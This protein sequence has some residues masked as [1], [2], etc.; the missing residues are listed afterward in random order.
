MP[1]RARPARCSAAVGAALC[2]LAGCTA[3]RTEP[4]V[5][6]APPA[7][8]KTI[9]VEAFVPAELAWTRLARRLRTRLTDELSQTGVVTL[10]AAQPAPQ[11]AQRPLVLSGQLV[12][13]DEGSETARFLIGMGLGSASLRARVRLVD[14]AGQSVLEFDQTRTSQAGSGLAAH[15]NPIDMDDEIDALAAATAATVARWLGGQTL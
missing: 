13:V 10:V 8:G 12:A 9:V 14:A 6:A 7:P 2:V 11:P 5:E 1:L 3:D 15:W 4:I